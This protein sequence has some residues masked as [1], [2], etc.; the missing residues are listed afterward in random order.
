MLRPCES[1]GDAMKYLCQRSL[2]TV[3]PNLITRDI[4]YLVE[5]NFRRYSREYYNWDCTGASR[6]CMMTQTLILARQF[7]ISHCFRQ[8]NDLHSHTAETLQPKYTEAF[9][10]Q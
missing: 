2:L 7:Y 9:Y 8:I 4:E 10:D 5:F 1:E 6:Q 3:L